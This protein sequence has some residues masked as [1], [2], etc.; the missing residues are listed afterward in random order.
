M[1]NLFR[2]KTVIVV[3]IIIILAAV[4]FYYEGGSSSGGSSLL[5]QQASDQSIGSAELNLLSQ[6]QSLKIDTS[7]F[8]D[9]GYQALVDYSVAIPAEDVGRPNPFAPFPGEVISSGASGSSG[10]AGH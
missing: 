1:K 6:I 4:Y 8:Q 5:V 9:P 10:T 7:L 3:I 2:S